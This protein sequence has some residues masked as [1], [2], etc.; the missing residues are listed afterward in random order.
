MSTGEDSKKRPAFFPEQGTDQLLSIVLELAA[1]L[2]TVRERMYVMEAVSAAQG[3]PLREAIE[4][5]RLSPTQQAELA[6]M[7]W[8]M[9]N[10][11]FRALGREHRQVGNAID[12]AE[13]AS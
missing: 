12:E 5:Y 2:W 11:L 9:T 10:N 3:R 7:R 8:R 1:E 4:S 13:S 6:D